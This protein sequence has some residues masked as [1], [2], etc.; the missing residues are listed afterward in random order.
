MNASFQGTPLVFIIRVPSQSQL[1]SGEI[2]ANSTLRVWPVGASG[3]RASVNATVLN[4]TATSVPVV[5]GNARSDLPFRVLRQQQS[6][7]QA[8]E[9]S[10]PG[11][12]VTAT[13]PSGG[14]WRV[15]LH[16]AVARSIGM[17][18]LTTADEDSP[19][20][21]GLHARAAAW[22]ARASGADGSIASERDVGSAAWY[23]RRQ[24]QQR[25]SQSESAPRPFSEWLRENL[26]RTLV[27]MTTPHNSEADTPYLAAS[28]SVDSES[29]GSPSRALASSLEAVIS[30]TAVD[31]SYSAAVSVPCG[32]PFGPQTVVVGDQGLDGTNVSFACPSFYA[33][34][35]CG[36]WDVAT[37][38]WAVGSCRVASVSLRGVVCACSRLGS[39]SFATRFS[40]VAKQQQAVFASATL[41]SH[42]DVISKYPTVFILVGSLAVSSTLAV[43]AF[44]VPNRFLLPLC[45]AR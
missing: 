21:P 38:G 43:G 45:G 18:P 39:A 30:S 3:L 35:S 7:G 5:G 40:S 14:E 19:G 33:V 22:L 25:V 16:E 42:S 9:D 31:V 11:P 2:A 32:P 20:V 13:A 6:D 17:S 4:V 15:W 12:P 23:A 37:S 27:F 10:P 44:E 1:A 28:D 36:A 26:L 29:T 24:R 41:L 34:P 8:P